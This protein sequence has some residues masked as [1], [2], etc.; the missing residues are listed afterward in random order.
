VLHMTYLRVNLRSAALDPSSVDAVQ[1][2]HDAS[3]RRDEVARYSHSRPGAPRAQQVI[4]GEIGDGAGLQM[5]TPVSRACSPQ[6]VLGRP[7]SR[8]QP[9]LGP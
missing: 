3:A 5:T 2:R 1:M 6:C 4:G 9:P 8:A 7:P